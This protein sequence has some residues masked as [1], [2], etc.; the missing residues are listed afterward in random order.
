MFKN[1]EKYLTKLFLKNVL[2][3]IIVF[4]FLSFFLNI[5]EE[6]KFF[7]NKDNNLYYPIILTILNIPSIIF[8][9][10]PFIFLLGVMF[11]FIS[12]FEKDEIE[13]LRSHGINNFKITTIISLVSLI[14][15]VLIIIIYYSFSANLKS[16]YLNI[17]YQYSNSGD[18]LA[19]V[20]EDGLW[21]KE[22][23][24]DESK[25]YIINATNYRKDTLENIKITEL[26]K[27]YKL[28]NTIIA[29]K[30]D[31][32]FNE[33]KLFN[34]KIYSDVRET[35][36]MIN[37]TYS[38]SFNGKIISNLYSNL[39]SLNIFQ[40]IKLKENYESIGYSAT[41]VKLHL[42]KIYSVPF[43][44]TLTTII[45][46]LLMFKLNFI[47]SKFFLIVIGVVVSVIFYYMN[48]FSILFGKNETFPVLVS[49][50]LPQVL[51]FLICGLGLTKLNEN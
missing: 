22:N 49:I 6:I 26:D 2:T 48:Y 1:Y 29:K 40:L 10:L 46:A 18:H 16:L 34:V 44:L 50:W 4:V 21:I 33:W 51:I 30:A 41:E 45:G 35:K 38:S 31:I 39:N 25:L 17:K 42:N 20:N 5:F 8:E 47:K 27:N 28:L 3:I 12:L 9:I 13:L 23:S 36:D 7:E 43:Y 15:G 37:Y 32:K 19:V 11:F 14:L 24:K